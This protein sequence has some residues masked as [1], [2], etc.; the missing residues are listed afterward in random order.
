MEDTSAKLN[1]TILEDSEDSSEGEDESV[2]IV[3][4]S[5]KL[6]QL[7]K[8]RNKL[9]K[10]L[11][12]KNQGNIEKV[13][14][15]L[16]KFQES[17]KDFISA[18]TEQILRKDVSTLSKIEFNNWFNSHCDTNKSFEA[19]VINWLNGDP[20]ENEFNSDKVSDPNSEGGST[21]TN[22]KVESNQ[23]DPPN[24]SAGAMLTNTL[25]QTNVDV[26]T[27]V[28]LQIL[29]T[30]NQI[31]QSILSNQNQQM[32]P[33]AQ[34]TQ[35]DGSNPLNFKPFI[36]AFDRIIASRTSDQAEL[37][38]RLLSYTKGE[39]HE[40]VQSC[41]GDPLTDAYQ[42]ARSKLE[43]KYNNQHIIGDHY[44]D[45]LMDWPAIPREDSKSL[46]KLSIFLEEGLSL[47]RDTTSL[48]SLNNFKVMERIAEKMPK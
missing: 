31:T 27:N 34:I 6:G 18:C 19:K 23:G 42:N 11:K 30:Q 21:K 45:K 36:L 15:Y 43:Q 39:A 35:F 48:N 4:P 26:S 3:Y 16:P 44:M 17:I 28:L 37:Y 25:N 24:I 1:K 14:A 29:Q 12:A 32:L 5:I 2:P 10:Y 9:L 20:S 7:T 22:S 13:T 8:Q 33:P 47:M 46:G 41:K 40:R 38:L